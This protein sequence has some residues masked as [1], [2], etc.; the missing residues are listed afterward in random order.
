MVTRVQNQKQRNPSMDSASQTDPIELLNICT[1]SVSSSSKEVEAKVNDEVVNGQEGYLEDKRV[2][3]SIVQFL[4]SAEQILRQEI[5]SS[6]H[7][8]K[9][10]NSVLEGFLLNQA[11][12]F[13]SVPLHSLY[14][15]HLVHRLG[16]EEN[17]K[18]PLNLSISAIEWN[19]SSSVIVIGY[20]MDRNSHYCD[21]ESFIC[22]WSLFRS[23]TRESRPSSTI[24]IDGCITDISSHPSLSSIFAIATASGQVLVIDSQFGSNSNSFTSGSNMSHEEGV[25]FLSWITGNLTSF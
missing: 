21:H 20:Q 3:S 10:L 11:T 24:E 2:A 22:I 9:E 17:G 7:V 13:T 14:S 25:S 23:Y 1:Q 5:H 4:L 15:D 16:K 6:I 8:S 18:N 19:C 12:E